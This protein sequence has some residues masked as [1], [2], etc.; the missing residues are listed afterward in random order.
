MPKHAE[1]EGECQFQQPHSRGGWQSVQQRV[2]G[3]PPAAPGAP[4]D[5]PGGVPFSP[6]LAVLAVDVH[7]LRLAARLAGAGP[8]RPNLSSHQ[9]CSGGSGSGS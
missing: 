9:D 6:V 1:T 3:S 7:G 5:A 4:V 8:L 2:R